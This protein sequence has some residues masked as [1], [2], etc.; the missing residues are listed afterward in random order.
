MGFCQISYYTRSCIFHTLSYNLQG[1][2]EK[3]MS[4][5][6]SLTIGAY[7]KTM[8]LY[9]Y[10]TYAW[11]NLFLFISLEYKRHIAYESTIKATVYVG[12][13]KACYMTATVIMN[14]FSLIVSAS[15]LFRKEDK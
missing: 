14:D 13:V 12:I 1:Y 6:L 15:T 2:H 7:L 10:V 5:C 8:F 4:I 9:T 11:G 3:T